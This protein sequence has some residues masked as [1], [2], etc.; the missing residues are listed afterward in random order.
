MRWVHRRCSDVPGQV[1]LL[2]CRDFFVCRTCLGD[3][4][5]VEENL[6]FKMTEDVLEEV[7]KFC[8][9]DNMIC[10]YGGASE[11]VSARIGTAWKKFRE[12]S[13]ALVGKQDLSLKQRGKIYQC[14]LRPVLLYCCERWVLTVADETRLRG[15]QRRMISLMCG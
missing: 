1:S 14:C 2:S 12:L 7:E 15:V 3:N 5:S 10:C 11:V 8:Y 4:C 13:G 6:E 9:L